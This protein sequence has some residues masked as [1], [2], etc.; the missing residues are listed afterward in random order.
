MLQADSI[1]CLQLEESTQ[2]SIWR[3]RLGHI[4]TETM[5]M[6]MKKELD[7]GIPRITIDKETCPSC[8]CGKQT[9]QPFLQATSYRVSSPLVLIHGDLFGPITPATLALKWYVFVLIDY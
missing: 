7:I 6:M 5:R 8:L 4:N 1:R 9:R 3:A 2:S